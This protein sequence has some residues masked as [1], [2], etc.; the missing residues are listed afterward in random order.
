MIL[1]IVGCYPSTWG[2]FLYGGM[3]I[4]KKWNDIPTTG[5]IVFVLGG[6]SLEWDDCLEIRMILSIVTCSLSYWDDS[7]YRWM[8]FFKVG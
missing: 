7:L 6:F 3:T 4:F 8:T 1:F 5:I 2:D